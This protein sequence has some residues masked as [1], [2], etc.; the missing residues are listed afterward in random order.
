MFV[1]LLWAA[2]AVGAVGDR[3]EGLQASMHPT[4]SMPASAWW[5]FAGTAAEL[6]KELIEAAQA[7]LLSRV[8]AAP[9][10]GEI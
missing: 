2:F 10:R 5:P 4:I 1:A 7:G 9:E 6:N 8:K 3:S